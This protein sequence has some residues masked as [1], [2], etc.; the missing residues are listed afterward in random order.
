[1]FG[2]KQ[3]LSSGSSQCRERFIAQDA[4]FGRGGVNDSFSNVF[5]SM[6]EE[7]QL[8]LTVA[9]ARFGRG[10]LRSHGVGWKDLERRRRST[11]LRIIDADINRDL[12]FRPLA[13]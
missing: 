6:L 13:P 5:P 4:N 3:E 11:R 8:G 9:A 2:A 7:S 10:T 1:M 12:P